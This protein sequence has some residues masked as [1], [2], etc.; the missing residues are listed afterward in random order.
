MA[1]TVSNAK[2]NFKVVVKSRPLIKRERDARLSSQW[3]ISGDSIESINPLITQRYTFGEYFGG[4]F[5]LFYPIIQCIFS[6]K[7]HCV[8]PFSNPCL[9]RM[10]FQ[11]IFTAKTQQHRSCTIKSHYRSSR[12]LFKDSMAPYLHMDKLRRVS[13]LWNTN[14]KETTDLLT[15]SGINAFLFVLLQVKHTRCW[16]TKRIRALFAWLQDRSSTI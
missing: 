2:D 12:N 13:I 11:I 8:V 15:L 6:S 7:F 1:S 14:L 16:V 5:A 10:C 3:K 9:C 4:I